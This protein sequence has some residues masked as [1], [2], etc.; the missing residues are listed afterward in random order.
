[1]IDRTIVSPSR[2]NLKKYSHA[3]IFAEPSEGKPFYMNQQ[4]PKEFLD[5]DRYTTP[6]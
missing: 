4:V 2:Q 5:L 6:G 1:M 3:T